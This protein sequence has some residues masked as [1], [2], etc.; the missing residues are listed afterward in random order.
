MPQQETSLEVLIWMQNGI[1]LRG[2]PRA[3]LLHLLNLALMLP[4]KHA[5]ARDV[6]PLPL[7]ILTHLLQDNSVIHTRLLQHRNQILRRERPVRAA[8]RLTGARQGLRGQ[9]LARVR[10]IA[11]ATAVG[12]A[13]DIAVRVTHVVAVLLVE[14][15]VRHQLEAAP[16]EDQ[17]LLEREAD[18]LQEERVLQTAEVLEVGVLAKCAVQV[19]HA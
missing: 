18:A 4:L 11:A 7:H 15:L 5:I 2:T 8:V 14:L 10:R 3:I 6:I 12:V 19:L 16:P 13:A 1:H 9:L 17:A